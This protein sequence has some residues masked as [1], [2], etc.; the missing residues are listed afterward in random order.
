[1]HLFV[2]IEV[3]DHFTLGCNLGIIAN[4]MTNVEGV[5]DKIVVGEG[6]TLRVAGGPRGEL[7]GSKDDSENISKPGCCRHRPS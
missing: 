2:M 4:A 1:M 5:V 7:E 6:D 3:K